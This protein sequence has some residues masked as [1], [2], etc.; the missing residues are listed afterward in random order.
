MEIWCLKN[1]TNQLNLM[2]NQL[3]KMTML[4]VKKDIMIDIVVQVDKHLEMFRK[5]EVMEKVI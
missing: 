1:N 5:K 4:L 2:K 3:L